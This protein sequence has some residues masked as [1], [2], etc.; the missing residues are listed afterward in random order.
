MLYMV[1]GTAVIILRFTLPFVKP[2]HRDALC[3]THSRARQ[4]RLLALLVI[5]IVAI[6]LANLERRLLPTLFLGVSPAACLIAWWYLLPMG[7]NLFRVL[8]TLGVSSVVAA[9]AVGST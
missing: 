9:F 7:L 6:G 3:M 1:L 8:V 2:E 5:T 4:S